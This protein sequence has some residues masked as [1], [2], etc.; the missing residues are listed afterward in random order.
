MKAPVK[1]KVITPKVGD[2]VMSRTCKVFGEP[3]TE[4]TDQGFICKPSGLW[5][6]TSEDWEI[7]RE[8]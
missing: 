2:T 5:E 1:P 3:V 6:G 7:T 4:V 8:A